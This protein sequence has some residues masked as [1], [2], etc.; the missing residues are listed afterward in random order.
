MMQ[1]GHHIVSGGRRCVG[2]LGQFRP[3]DAYTPDRPGPMKARAVYLS[4]GWADGRS[5]YV[6][7]VADPSQ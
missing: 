3:R 5:G 4:L 7:A 2:L 1:M 6:V